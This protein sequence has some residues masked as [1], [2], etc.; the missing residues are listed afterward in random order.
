M[1][2]IYLIVIFSI[3]I[4]TFI[5]IGYFI[6]KPNTNN[7]VYI[8]DD[9][10]RN[11]ERDQLMSVLLENI[12][13][14]ALII[15]LNGNVKAFNY[16]FRNNI[17]ISAQY[18][19]NVYD[20]M[21]YLK[22]MIDKDD[23]TREIMINKQY[24]SVKVSLLEANIIKGYLVIFTNINSLK[25]YSELQ[26]TFIENAMHELKT[27]LTSISGLSQIMIQDEFND[28]DKAKQFLK[29]IDEENKR[30]L[31]L[32]NNISKVKIYDDLIEIDLK[33]LFDKLEMIFSSKLA[34]KNLVLHKSV[35]STNKVFTS[36]EGLMQIL[37][38]IIENAI[39]YTNSGSIKLYSMNHNDN[40]MIIISDTGV[41]IDFDKQGLIFERFYKTDQSRYSDDNSYG[42]GLSIVKEIC[43]LLD[44]K[45]IVDSQI[46]KGT[47]FYLEI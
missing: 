16:E 22:E 18:L 37:T 26:K 19:T 5:V 6:F 32:V 38:N 27:P 23:L 35:G 45:I 29:V 36:T 47:T 14:P 12:K 17:M 8:N 34:N 31:K 41:G 15:S 28:L 25:K 7:N 4:L 39:K 40:V 11:E 1:L 13:Q 10:L 24:Y 43:D 2:V 9:S 20:K 33:E 21:Y 30:L 44:I 46:N 3:I 42:L